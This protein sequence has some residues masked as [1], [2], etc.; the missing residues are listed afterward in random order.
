M[1]DDKIIFNK[2]TFDQQRF[3]SELRRA[4]GI[5]VITV[6]ILSVLIVGLFALRDNWFNQELRTV[7]LIDYSLS[8]VLLFTP[9]V[10][11]K[12]FN[13]RLSKASC[14]ITQQELKID[15]G[16]YIDRQTALI[17]ELK[18][19]PFAL[20][21]HILDLELQYLDIVYLLNSIV[22]YQSGSAQINKT[23]E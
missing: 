22:T 6:A 19:D 1:T 16:D 21:K 11:I 18:D 12:I 10:T 14:F 17:S 20:S 4:R 8:I 2:V 15:R 9:I 13:W 7:N 3:K 5:E 23:K